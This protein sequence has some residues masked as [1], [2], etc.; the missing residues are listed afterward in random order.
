M[1]CTALC[2]TAHLA[3][4][5]GEGEVPRGD[6]AHHAHRLLQHLQGGRAAREGSAARTRFTL[7]HHLTPPHTAAATSAH[8]NARSPH[9][10]SPKPHHTAHRHTHTH[11]HTHTPTHPP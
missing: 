2:C 11:T 8:P 9:R 5:H 7:T 4:D 10:H 1:Y 3:G 6:G